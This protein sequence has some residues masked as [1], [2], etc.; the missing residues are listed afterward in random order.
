MIIIIIISNGKEPQH[1]T[2]LTWEVFGK[3]RKK[4]QK[5]G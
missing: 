1:S 3:R 5:R 4:G 2:G